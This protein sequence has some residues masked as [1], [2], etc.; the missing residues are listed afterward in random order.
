MAQPG[1]TDK[2]LGRRGPGKALRAPPRC[3]WL[4][5]VS[6]KSRA[7]RRS[8]PSRRAAAAR[9]NELPEREPRGVLGDSF[10][11][12]GPV[13]SG[14]D[15]GAATYRGS[16][17][18]RPPRQE[19]TNPRKDRKRRL[20]PRRCSRHRRGPHGPCRSS[21]SRNA[22]SRRS[23]ALSST[24]EPMYAAPV[25]DLIDELGRLPGIGPK[26]AQRIA[27]YISQ[28]A[29]RGCRPPGGVDKCRQDE[30]HLVPAVFQRR[31]GREGAEC[32]ICTDASRDPRSCAS[33][34]NLATSSRSKKLPSSGAVTT[35]YRERS[36]R[37]T[38]SAPS[39][40]GCG[41]CLAAD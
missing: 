27:F 24:S 41:S 20:R 28:V 32:D 30:S 7:V 38:A 21:P 12:A 4:V 8:L 19:D 16:H 29:R 17:R 5:A 13:A 22:Y 31:G 9:A 25:Q 40:C 15:K 23:Q 2:G 18:R 10:R 35:C 14:P 39:N 3:T 34:R 6:W 36:A 26:S 33:S 37:S 1:R 11:A